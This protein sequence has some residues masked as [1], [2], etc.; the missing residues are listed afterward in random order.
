MAFGFFGSKLRLAT[1]LAVICASCA[2]MAG[3]GPGTGHVKGRVLLP[4]GSPLPGGRISFIAEDG[5]GKPGAGVIKPDGTYDVPSAPV[6]K[7][8]ITINNMDLKEGGTAAPIGAGNLGMGQGKGGMGPPKDSTTGMAGKSDLKPPESAYTAA[9]K[10]S[11]TYVQIDPK[12][13]NPGE[14]GLKYEVKRGTQDH[15]IKLPQ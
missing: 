4:D 11:G 2:F 10:I 6:G 12:Y 8:N 5:K 15:E 7:V 13:A 9:E 1:G 3:C 14:S